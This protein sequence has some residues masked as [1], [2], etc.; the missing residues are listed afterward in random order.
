M[1]TSWS[2]K[3]SASS[4][5]Y[6]AS[7]AGS[8]DGGGGLSWS[9]P[10]VDPENPNNWRKATG[11]EIDVS[12]KSEQRVG[13]VDNDVKAYKGELTKKRSASGAQLRWWYVAKWELFEEV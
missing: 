3:A 8:P 13:P 6:D 4:G 11:A 5:G 12:S 1:G 7:W 2:V 10:F 9:A